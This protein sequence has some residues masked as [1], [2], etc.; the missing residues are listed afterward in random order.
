MRKELVCMAIVLGFVLAPMASLADD[1]QDQMQRMEDRMAQMEDRLQATNDQ[2]DAA[3]DV[4]VRQQEII[5]RSGIADQTAGSSGVAAFLDSLELGG[6]LAG[7]YFYNFNDPNGENIGGANQGITGFAYPFH[8]DHDSFS[9]DQLWFEMERPVTESNRAGFRADLCYGKICDILSNGGSGDGHS[10]SSDDFNL[11]QA[12][13]QYLA[14]V[15]EGVTFKFGK[16]GT[17]IGAEVAPTVYNMNITRGHVYNLL[18]PVTQVGVLAEMEFGDGFHGTIGYINESVTANDTDLNLDQAFT[19]QLGWSGET[20]GVNLSGTYGSTNGAINNSG[21][22]FLSGVPSSATI[23]AGTGPGGSCVP[24]ASTICSLESDKEIIG[25]IVVTWDPTPEFSGWLNATYREIDLSQTKTKINATTG[26][27][28]STF[29]SDA[30]AWGVAAAGRYA[31]N[32]KLGMALRAEYLS[33]EDGF[34]TGLAFLGAA[35][36][37]GGVPCGVPGRQV[38][39]M[40]LTGTMDY[41]LTEQLMVRGEVRYDQADVNRASDKIFFADGNETRDFEN[42]QITAGVEVI[43]N[44]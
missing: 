19:G 6:W 30:A 36:C 4:V 34:F 32:E 29:G 11:Y 14:P 25:D 44:F 33:D 10:G 16:F 41:S 26:Q 12:Y 37:S 39:L 22:A 8:P 3:N 13:I 42:D 38:E 23:G 35:T 31:L 9:V 27:F 24:G 40:S 15:G 18:Q 17:L 5:D 7:S 2:L 21:V 28:P 43:Y 20:L 1:V